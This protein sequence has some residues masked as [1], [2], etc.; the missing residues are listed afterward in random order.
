MYKFNSDNIFTG[1]IKQ[2]LASFNLPKYRVY[3]REQEAHHQNYLKFA[4]T[5]QQVLK[6]R[7]AEREQ[8]QAFLAMVEQEKEPWKLI[9]SDEAKTESD[10]QKAQAKIDNITAKYQAKVQKAQR[11]LKEITE[12]LRHLQPE[13]NV[14]ETVYRTHS[15]V[16]KDTLQDDN[17]ISYPERM[18]YIP[19]IKD[20]IIQEC[21]NGEWHKCHATLD[22]D[23]DKVHKPTGMLGHIQDYTYNQKIE[24]YTKN[25]KVQNNIY[26]S[27]THEYLGDYLRFHRDFANINLMPLYNCF[28]SRACPKLDIKFTLQSGY[29][30]KFN[31]DD[32]LYKYYMVPVKFFQDYTI[33]IDSEAAIEVCCC[34][35]DQ[36]QVKEKNATHK[37]ALVELSK[38]TY[39]CFSDMQFRIP[40]LYSQ[41]KNLNELLASNQELELAQQEYAL[42]LILKVPVENKSSIVILEGD[43]TTYGQSIYTD[44]RFGEKLSEADNLKWNESTKAFNLV[45]D[46][47]NKVHHINGRALGGLSTLKNKRQ[48]SNHTTINLSSR[49]AIRELSSKLITPLQLLRTNTGESYPFADRLIEYLVGN[50]ITVNEEIPDNV[51]RAKKVISLN[52]PT[53]IKPLVSTDGIW[54]PLLQCL[55][56]NYINNK[57]NVNDINHD[58]LGYIDKDVEKVYSGTSYEKNAEGQLVPKETLTIS[59]ID[60]YD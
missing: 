60:I 31:T 5:N 45:W 3:T 53:E 2:L 34:L 17:K 16:Y 29:E 47:K 58:I 22:P 46:K 38:A 39:Q 15:L 54:E 40:R 23:H 6:W 59:D 13:I 30:V 21:V 52:C 33:A 57:H 8:L 24:N 32:T 28:S 48:V 4:S 56:Y 1:Y 26:D 12:E 35:Y 43:Y 9:L 25:L 50:A 42:K 7:S 20:G 19:Y 49:K 14:L 37:A 10:K 44:A 55:V 36:Y 18:R 11:R 41:I 51:I 27:Y